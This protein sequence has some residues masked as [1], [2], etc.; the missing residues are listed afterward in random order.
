M[1]KIVI[2][3]FNKWQRI[4]AHRPPVSL[5]SRIGG[6]NAFHFSIELEAF[7]IANDIEYVINPIEE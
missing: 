1:K 4:R 3:N 2:L 5:V 6:W 7:L